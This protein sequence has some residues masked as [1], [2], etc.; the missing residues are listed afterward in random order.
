MKEDKTKNEALTSDDSQNVNRQTLEAR[1]KGVKKN[2]KQV[3]SR[4]QR[5]RRNEV[6]GHVVSDRMDKT[7]TVEI[8]RQVRHPRLGKYIKR[9]TQ[10]KV[11]DEKNTAHKGD[12][13]LIHASRK[14][15]KTKCWI[16]S[17]VIESSERL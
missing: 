12:K 8:Y 11:H 2:T 1:P 6:I 9:S 15:S 5:G 10:F 3:A 14:L 7:I 16:L 4:K 17:K 13:V